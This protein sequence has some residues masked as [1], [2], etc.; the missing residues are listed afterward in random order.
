M[1]DS[2]FETLKKADKYLIE[3]RQPSPAEEQLFLKEVDFA[4][5]LC[6][7][8]LRNHQQPKNNKLYEIAHIYPNSPT[9]EQYTALYGVERLGDNCEASENKIALCK[10]C[11]DNQDYHTTRADYEKLL[12]IKK[13]GE[14]E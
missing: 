5:P 11:H 4:C 12:N 13:R 9:R 7:K 10:D 8:D 3:R 2:E 6:G 14:N 1:G